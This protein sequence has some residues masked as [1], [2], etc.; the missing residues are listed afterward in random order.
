MGYRILI[1]A[2]VNTSNGSKVQ[3]IYLCD[4]SGELPTAAENGDL[5]II[6]NNFDSFYVRNG[7]WVE[8]RIK[9]EQGE[10]GDIE[11]AWPETSVI[12]VMDGK[13]PADLLGFGKWE[14]EEKL[15]KIIFWKRLA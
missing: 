7:N 13:N 5:A 11:K 3:S 12:G 8:H 1:S 9:G 6:K 4:T 15:G 10:P 14:E 2:G